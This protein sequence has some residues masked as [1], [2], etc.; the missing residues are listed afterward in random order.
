MVQRSRQVLRR[1]IAA[2]LGRNDDVAGGSQDP[3][4]QARG[5]GFDPL[6]LLSGCY[7]GPP[8]E[9]TK[10]TKV[11]LKSTIGILI[12]QSSKLEAP[13]GHQL[14]WARLIGS[15]G[16]LGCGT[17]LRCLRD[18]I[19]NFWLLTPRMA[20]G[21]PAMGTFQARPGFTAFSKQARPQGTYCLARPVVTCPRKSFSSPVRKR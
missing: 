8:S 3:G 19:L 10:R 13:G 15:V 4:S 12:M 20:H 1:S 18:T 6:L 16:I 7:L 14:F 11:H 21:H 5:R 9:L 17:L 2:N